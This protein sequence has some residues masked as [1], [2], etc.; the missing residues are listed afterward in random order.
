MFVVTV[1]SVADGD[2]VVFSHNASIDNLRGG[3]WDINIF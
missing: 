1:V 3:R 2:S